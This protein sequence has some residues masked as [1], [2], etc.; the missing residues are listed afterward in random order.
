MKVDLD[1]HLTLM[2]STLYRILAVG[3]GKGHEMSKARTLFRRL[4]NASAN[5]TITETELIITLGRRTNNP[6]RLAAECPEP[7]PWLGNRIH[8]NRF[9]GTSNPTHK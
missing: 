6:L 1:L 9:A 4:F 7:I 3:A 5:I 8:T 2:A